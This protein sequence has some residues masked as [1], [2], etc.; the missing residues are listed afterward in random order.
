MANMHKKQRRQDR[1]GSVM[2]ARWCSDIAPLSKY[3]NEPYIVAE[4][5]Q[6]NSYVYVLSKIHIALMQMAYKLSINYETR[7]TYFEQ[8]LNKPCTSAQTCRH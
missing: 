2:M 1:D 4:V 8:A 3:T 5:P 6:Y 7:V